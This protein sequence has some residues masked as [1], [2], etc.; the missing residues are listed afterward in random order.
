MKINYYFLWNY[1]KFPFV[2]S[3]L[4]KEEINILVINTEKNKN[5]KLQLKELE[6][7]EKIKKV[8][9]IEN[10]LKNY[11]LSILY[12]IFIFPIKT[13]K[14]ISL[15][16]DGIPGNIP[17]FLAN[18]GTPSNFFYYEEGESLYVKNYIFLK[19]LKVFL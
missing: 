8:I 14:E 12:R 17:I 1:N 19:K 3:I 7:L 10:N 16:I 4:K 18:L 5:L 2:Y 15:F 6:K 11:I 13:K 9:L